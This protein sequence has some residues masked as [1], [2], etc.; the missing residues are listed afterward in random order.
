[1]AP[2]DV[3]VE[4]GPQHGTLLLMWLPVSIGP[5]NV[6]NGTPITGYSIYA[7]NV[8]VSTVLGPTSEC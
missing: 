8:K 4:A 6:S 3:Q 1:M 2:L 5:T 7:D